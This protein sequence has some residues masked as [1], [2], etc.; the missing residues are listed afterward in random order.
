MSGRKYVWRKNYD[1]FSLAKMICKTRN[2]SDQE[3][4][5]CRIYSS[6]MFPKTRR[7][8]KRCPPCRRRRSKQKDSGGTN[9]EKHRKIAFCNENNFSQCINDPFFR[10]CNQLNETTFEVEMSKKTIT[11]DLPLRISCFVHQYAKLR[12]L[13]IYYDFMDTFVD[14]R[15]C[16]YCCMD[17]DAAYMGL[18]VDSLEEVI[19]PELRQRYQSEKN[20]W[21]PRSDTL[22]HAAY[23]KRTRGSSKKNTEMELLP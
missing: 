20:N 13:E 11:L 4:S 5:S 10:Q 16:Q 9:K 23:D 8:N 15:D 17:T 14:R 21:F 3:L 7:T 2:T 6:Q 12:M 1:H 19:K 22:E 18:S